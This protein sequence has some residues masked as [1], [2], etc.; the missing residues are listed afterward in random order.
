[1]HPRV[2]TD[3]TNIKIK[4]TEFD[5]GAVLRLI[6]EYPWTVSIVVLVLFS[7]WVF[8]PGGFAIEFFKL[9]QQKREQEAKIETERRELVLKYRSQTVIPPAA[10]TPTL[11]SPTSGQVR[12]GRSERRR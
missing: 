6:N 7:F 5:L 1:M 10:S 4:D 3:S 11:P 12:R 9:R 8:R 2:G